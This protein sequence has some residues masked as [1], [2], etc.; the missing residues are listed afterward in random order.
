MDEHANEMPKYSGQI[1]N[2]DDLR[3][4]AQAA[5]SIIAKRLEK[6]NE[7]LELI[8]AALDEKSKETPAAIH[9]QKFA[10]VQNLVFEDMKQHGGGTA[11]EIAKRMSMPENSI[12]PGLYRLWHKGKVSLER[13]P[14][15]HGPVSFYKIK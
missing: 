13:V 9:Q 8:L 6:T 15:L 5:L 12:G 11:G 10:N 7:L 14:G 3:T 4:S 1:G 2:P